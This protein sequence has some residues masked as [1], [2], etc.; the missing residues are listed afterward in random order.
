MKCLEVMDKIPDEILR[1]NAEEEMIN[2]EIQDAFENASDSIQN[3]ENV[4]RNCYE[5][6]EKNIDTDSFSLIRMPFNYIRTANNFRNKYYLEELI[7]NDNTKKNISY[8]L[9]LSDL[10]NYIL[11]RYELYGVVF[12][13]LYKHAITNIVTVQEAILYGTLESLREFCYLGKEN[14]LC[15]K[16]AKCE[17]YLK[18]KNKLKFADLIDVYVSKLFFGDQALKTTLLEL[19]QIRDSIHIQD[20]RFNEW[21]NDKYYSKEKYNKAILVLRYFSIH[22]LISVNCF[23][24]R[25]NNGCQK[26]AII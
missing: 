23:K 21:A 7:S 12:S 16:N 9:Q 8:A 6:P 3:L 17:F 2:E 4:I 24:E 18:S 5:T 26:K 1:Q 13:L 22:L 11:N 25:R 20:V 15:C 19:K 14:K 10:Y